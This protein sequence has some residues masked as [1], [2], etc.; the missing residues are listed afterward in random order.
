MKLDRELIFNKLL[1]VLSE[2]KEF[3]TISRK[4]KLWTEI[5]PSDMPALFITQNRDAVQTVRGMDQQITL[6]SDLY[7]Y[8]NIGNEIDANPYTE[9]NPLVDKISEL[10]MQQP[11]N[12]QTLGG[13]VHSAKVNGTVEYSGGLLGTT[14]IAIIPIE[15]IV[16]I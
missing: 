11:Y 5:S 1:E 3:S 6:Y 13:L 8:I 15:I 12:M 10:F 14:A 2:L 7:L 9:L 4:L 16:N